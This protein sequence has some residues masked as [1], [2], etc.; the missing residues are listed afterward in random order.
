MR[1]RGEKRFGGG[2]GGG[3]GGGVWDD[4]DVDVRYR[5]MELSSGGSRLNAGRERTQHTKQENPTKRQSQPIKRSYH[6][7]P[8]TNYPTLKIIRWNSIYH[9]FGKVLRGV[10]RYDTERPIIQD[11][12]RFLPRRVSCRL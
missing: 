2:S 9:C 8:Q 1:T 7:I 10:D 12:D 5:Q 11:R 3:G 4:N 6:I